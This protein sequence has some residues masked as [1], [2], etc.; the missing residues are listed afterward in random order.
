MKKDKRS[1]E[2]IRKEMD[3][4]WPEIVRWKA[5]N[6]RDADKSGKAIAKAH[7]SYSEYATRAI[8]YKNLVNDLMDAEATERNKARAAN[9]KRRIK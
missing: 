9:P 5:Q 4:L 3:D 2:E 6:D 8:K 7:S 1:S